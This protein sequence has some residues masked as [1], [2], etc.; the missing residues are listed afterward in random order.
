M[1]LFADHL[2]V[3]GHG[4][5]VKCDLTADAYSY[6]RERLLV[7]QTSGCRSGRIAVQAMFQQNLALCCVWRTRPHEF[8]LRASI[9]GPCFLASAS[10]QSLNHL[11]PIRLN[12]DVIAF[13]K[14]EGLYRPRTRR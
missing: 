4:V 8:A 12:A 2:A 3:I 1:G 9:V 14:L 11:R 10:D 7:P 13:D 5:V 6:D